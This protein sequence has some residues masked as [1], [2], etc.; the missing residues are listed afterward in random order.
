MNSLFK[1]QKILGI[2]FLVSLSVFVI[3][4]FL[5]NRLPDKSLIDPSL[6]NKPVQ[7]TTETKK[8]EVNTSDLTYEITPLYDYELNGLV[9]S[10]ANNE[11]WYSRFRKSDPLNTKDICVVYGKNIE[12]SVYQ[13]AKFYSEEFVCFFKTDDNAVYAKFSNED[14][15]NNHL[16]AA[17]N[18]NA[19]VYEELRKAKV[20]D[21][22]SLKGYLAE[23][24]A[25]KNNTSTGIGRSSST[26]RTDTGMG[27]CEAIYL[28]DFKILKTGNPEISMINIFSKYFSV[29]FLIGYLLILLYPMHSSRDY[30]GGTLNEPTAPSLDDLLPTNLTHKNK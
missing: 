26:T 23:Y 14:L 8:F 2:F 25:K 15:S 1:L 24:S 17:K 9:V 13:N 19:S 4:F 20:G 21:Q 3:T 6:F 5:Q 30:G 10:V 28:T 22:V 18:N 29:I 12:N 27:A 11:V 7:K 16:L